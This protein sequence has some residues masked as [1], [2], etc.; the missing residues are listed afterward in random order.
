MIH[1][2]L[3]DIQYLLGVAKIHQS[4][5]AL[6]NVHDTSGS[7]RTFQLH[8]GPSGSIITIYD[9]TRYSGSTKPQ[10]GPS[11]AVLTLQDPPGCVKELR[12]PA[13][14]HQGLQDPPGSTKTI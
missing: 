11:G 9:P 4:T 12:G 1:Q 8:Q 6:R 2:D 7:A 14:T 10:Q 13:G 3:W 5:M